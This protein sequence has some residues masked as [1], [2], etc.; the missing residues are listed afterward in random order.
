MGTGQDYRGSE[1]EFFI[2]ILYYT[3]GFVMSRENLTPSAVPG[4]EYLINQNSKAPPM[5][6]D[7]HKDYFGFLQAT[8]LRE[9]TQREAN[10]VAHGRVDVYFSRDGVKTVAE[11]KKTHDD[12]SLNELVDKFGLQATAYQRTNVTFCI[13]MVLDLVDRG[14]GSDHLRN[15]VGVHQ[16]IPRGGTTEYSVVTL[17]VQ[18]RKKFPSAL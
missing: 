15:L 4:V 5:E 6:A 18:G 9:L 10:G 14:G 7:L 12:F 11:L 17:R 8:P 2:Q 3:I 13:L 16:K 1:Q